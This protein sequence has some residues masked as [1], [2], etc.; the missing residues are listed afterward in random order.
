MARSNVSTPSP[1]RA[2]T[3]DEA[4]RRYGR[5][6]WVFS[7]GERRCYSCDRVI[8]TGE[9]HVSFG[10]RFLVHLCEDCA[11]GYTR[12]CPGCGEPTEEG[13]CWNQKCS[14]GFANI[15]EAIGDDQYHA[16]VDREVED[17]YLE[18]DR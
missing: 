5:S 7:H 18:M 10:P 1:I 2:T 3:L 6:T 9:S 16:G 12:H 4:T 14:E 11:V 13:T 8:P 17:Y 15:Q